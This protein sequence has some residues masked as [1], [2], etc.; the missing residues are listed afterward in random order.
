MSN[1]RN[2]SYFQGGE[3]ITILFE[4]FWV[5]PTYVLTSTYKQYIR[6]YF[7]RAQKKY[8]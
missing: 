4:T 8:T 6:T 3:G 5:L 1:K 2:V 7:Y